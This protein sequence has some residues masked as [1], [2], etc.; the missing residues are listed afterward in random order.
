VTE[1][2]LNSLNNRDAVYTG[3]VESII[4]N[5]QE[6]VPETD[7]VPKVSTDR[8]IVKEWLSSFG[9]DVRMGTEEWHKSSS[10]VPSHKHLMGRIS[11]ESS[12]VG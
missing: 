5:G 4:P 6:L 1:L 3:I 8:L 12:H 11:K 2:R 10:L 7:G 9:I